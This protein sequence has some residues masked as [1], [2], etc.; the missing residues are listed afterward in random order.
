M[1]LLQRLRH[2]LNTRCRDNHLPCG[3]P[4]PSKDTCFPPVRKHCF[5]LGIIPA[6]PF[7]TASTSPLPSDWE[8]PAEVPRLSAAVLPPCQRWQE[9]PSS[10]GAQ[11]LPIRRPRLSRHPGYM[12]AQKGQFSSLAFA[13][14]QSISDGGW[15]GSHSIHHTMRGTPGN[16]T[17]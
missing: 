5:I 16:E 15:G 3:P 7:D 13:Q 12:Q 11:W 8:H 14:H 9:S 4:P 1:P 6:T 17:E 2:C 10:T